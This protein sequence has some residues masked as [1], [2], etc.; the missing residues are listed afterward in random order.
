MQVVAHNFDELS[1]FICNT[2]SSF[3]TATT[4]AKLLKDDPY[5]RY[6]V[7]MNEFILCVF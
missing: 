5:G 2:Y 7:T 1:M 6:V 3:F 4:F